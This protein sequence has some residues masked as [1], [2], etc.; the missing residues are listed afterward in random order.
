MSHQDKPCQA[1][2]QLP[3]GTRYGHRHD[4]APAWAMLSQRVQNDLRLWDAP[5]LC[6]LVFV[7]AF[8]NAHRVF[9]KRI[10]HQSHPGQSWRVVVRPD[11]SLRSIDRELDDDFHLHNKLWRFCSEHQSILL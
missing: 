7:D 10:T 9:A 3:S 4:P 8:H 6:W 2:T 5:L 11:V 1:L